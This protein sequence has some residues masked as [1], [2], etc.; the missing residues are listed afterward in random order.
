MNFNII[1]SNVRILAR[2]IHFFSR[3]GNELYLE[4]LPTG[5]SLKVINSASTAFVVAN[6]S[7][8]YFM[9]FNQGADEQFEQNNC[10]V[11]IKPL[12]KIFKSIPKIIICKVWLDLQRMKIIFRFECKS[13]VRKTHTISL[14]EYEGIRP[15]RL[16]EVF[17]M[18]IIGNHTIFGR[19][20][21]H[22]HRSVRE[23]TLDAK[24]DE[25]VVSNYI[26][27]RETD[28]TT[29]RSKLSI[30]SAAFMLYDLES[31]SNITFCY[32]EFKA[33]AYYAGQNKMNV[34][35]NFDRAGSPIMI[36]MK[37]D[38]VLTIHFIMGT[39]RP[40]IRS[41]KRSVQRANRK[42]TDNSRAKRNTMAD[43]ERIDTCNTL[44][45]DR[46]QMTEFEGSHS[47]ARIVLDRRKGTASKGTNTILDGSFFEGIHVPPQKSSTIIDTEGAGSSRTAS[48]VDNARNQMS[49]MEI[50]NSRLRDNASTVRGSPAPPITTMSSLPEARRSEV[51]SRSMFKD[52]ET[53]ERGNLQA[54]SVDSM[55]R[56]PDS[57][58]VVFVGNTDDPNSESQDHIATP[59][60][61]RRLL[62]LSLQRSTPPP[63]AICSNLMS[64]DSERNEQASFDRIS[65]PETLESQEAIAERHRKEQKMRHIF[66]KC[67]EDTVDPRSL[68]T[69]SQIFAENSDPED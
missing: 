20:L 32:K 10:K 29:L 16:P 54:N 55:L 46:T 36:R 11:S 3:I 9:H 49:E 14:L 21:L 13:C 35:M 43:S 28:R 24:T 5:L 64:I 12:L 61:K 50:R 53:L 52:V 67:F 22:I 40:K 45:D 41:Q 62:S 7:K 42:L 38:D 2:T 57:Y 66:K 6:I 44:D 47:E 63:I 65:I 19:I 37:K 51:A 30:S 31:P 34:E 25:V 27:N 18:K 48:F 69:P 15:L 60:N 17:P 1:G 58:D 39:M 23:V 8:K 33:M 4:A 56:R 59:T 26:E 68:I